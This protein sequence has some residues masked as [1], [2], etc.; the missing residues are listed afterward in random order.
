LFVRGGQLYR[1]FPFTEDSLV[2]SVRRLYLVCCDD[3]DDEDV[4]ERADEDDD[5]EDE[6]DKDLRQET[7]QSTW[8]KNTLSMPWVRISYS[9]R[10]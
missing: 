10:R 1:S 7:Q 4:A 2:R 6:R 5:A 8:V 9:V 3:G